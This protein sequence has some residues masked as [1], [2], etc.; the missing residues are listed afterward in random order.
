V[1]LVALIPLFGNRHSASRA[2]ETL[3]RDFA[4]DLLN[5]VEPY[6]I[7][8]TA[9]DNDTFPLWY[10]QEVE[11]VREDVTIVNLSLANTDWH[12]RQLQRRAL[13]TFDSAAA[14][15]I[16]Q[17]KT[18]PKPAAP[19]MSFT[20]S[21]LATLQLFYLVEKPTA[22]PLGPITVTLDPQQLGRQ[23]VER[24]DIAVLQIIK[25]HLG[26]TRPIYFSRT[27]GDYAERFGLSRHL[28]GHGFARVLRPQPVVPSDSVVQVSLLGMV[29][30]R[31]T[32]ALLFDVYHASAAT[33]L[34]PR[35][36]VDRPSEGILTTYGLLYSALTG[37]LQQH[38]PA[39]A[40]RAQ[41]IAD[42]VFANTDIVLQ[43]PPGGSDD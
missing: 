28:E 39:L 10:A 35:G 30:V 14:P 6:G 27:V 12:L 15:R 17:G 23:Y 40:A 26:T 9:G 32:A 5:S 42:S 25:D 21:Q 11:H 3:A 24:A 16:Y 33:R 2:G 13:P 18:W 20:E 19:L 31:R 4:V 43:R 37:P 8:V 7:L 41:A 38:D 36:W 34:R 22:L 29:N 1:L